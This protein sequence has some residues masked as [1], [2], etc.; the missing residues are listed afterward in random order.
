MTFII[1]LKKFSLR[2]EQNFVFNLLVQD[3]EESLDKIK[4]IS[5]ELIE[6]LFDIYFDYNNDEEN[7]DD[8]NKDNKNKRERESIDGDEKDE[9]EEEKKIKD[10]KYFILI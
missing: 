1:L 5:D 10:S 3:N 6:Q 8:E 7:S 4:K 9:D 2:Y